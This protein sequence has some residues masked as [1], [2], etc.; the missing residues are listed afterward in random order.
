MIEND[1]HKLF[2]MKTGSQVPVVHILVLGN[3]FLHL[4]FFDFWIDL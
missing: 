3:T 4:G 2:R 1:K